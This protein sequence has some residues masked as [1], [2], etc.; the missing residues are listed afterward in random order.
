[1]YSYSELVCKN[2]WKGTQNGERERYAGDEQKTII[3][4]QSETTWI[5]PCKEKKKRKNAPYLKFKMVS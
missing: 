3:N 5:E 4:R 1:M 2:T